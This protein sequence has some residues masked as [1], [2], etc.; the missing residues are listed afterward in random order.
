MEL[1]FDLLSWALLV[2]GGLLS[3]VGGIGLIRLPDLFCRMHAAGI[4]DTLGMGLMTLGLMVQSGLSLITV[5]LLFIAIF[6]LFTSP[7][8]THALAKAA[9]H[10]G[11][12]PVPAKRETDR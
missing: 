1:V 10:G 7:T 2:A 9:L 4:I 12:P 6:I 8:S 5:K 3:I 11:L